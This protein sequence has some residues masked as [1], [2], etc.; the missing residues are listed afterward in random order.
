MSLETGRKN[1]VANVVQP[2]SNGP[3]FGFHTH[4]GVGGESFKVPKMIYH[5]QHGKLSLDS[6]APSGGGPPKITYSHMRSGDTFEMP[7]SE[8][9]KYAAD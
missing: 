1:I 7:H 2:V 4:I 3:L 8:A 9:M 5:P 6:V